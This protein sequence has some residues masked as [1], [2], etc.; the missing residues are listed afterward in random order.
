M[1]LQNS[2]QNTSCVTIP[3]CLWEVSVFW[4]PTSKFSA[5]HYYT[6][7]LY[8]RV[9]T[10]IAVQFWSRLWTVGSESC[11]HHH[12]YHRPTGVYTHTHRFGLWSIRDKVLTSVALEHDLVVSVCTNIAAWHMIRPWLDP[13]SVALRPDPPMY[14]TLTPPYWLMIR[15]WSGPFFCRIGARPAWARRTSQSLQRMNRL[16]VG[17]GHHRVAAW[18]TFDD[19]LVSVRLLNDS[20]GIWFWSLPHPTYSD[21]GDKKTINDA[22]IRW[23]QNF[24][25]FHNTY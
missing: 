14:Y 10:H 20:D 4:E 1:G 5:A 21:G 23:W 8:R 7:T 24:F 12:R 22:Y 3:S 25:Q 9:A 13:Y 16:V 19:C 6:R 18:S 15:P 11:S 2:L 17:H